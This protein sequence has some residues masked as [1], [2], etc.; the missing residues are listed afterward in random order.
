[1]ED[2][3]MQILIIAAVSAAAITST[4]FAQ[5]TSRSESVL[6]TAVIDGETITVQTYG[7][8]RLLGIDAPKIARGG[9][10]SAPM[11]PLAIVARDRLSSL[12]LRR[13]VRLETDGARLDVRARHGAYVM[14]ED[15]QCINAVL[16]R[17]G[18]ARVSSRAPLAR[19]PEL[20]RAEADAQA[21][22][23]GLWGAPGTSPPIPP[24]SYTRPAGAGQST[25]PR[26]T[27][28][29]S[30]KKKSAA[31]KTQKTTT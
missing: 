16:V 24:A 27:A 6:V 13:F 26:A 15:G 11:A 22:H 4:A 9:A 30:S 3:R 28:P 18:L 7:R 5:T 8:V 21:A 20:R 17:E 1:M 2:S 12:V 31:K 14:T 29:R 19:L 10:G 23:R 25:P